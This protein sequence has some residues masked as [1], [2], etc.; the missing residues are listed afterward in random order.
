MPGSSSQVSHVLDAPRPPFLDL[1]DE[2]PRTALAG[3]YE[4]AWRLLTTRPPSVFRQLPEEEREDLISLI[5]ERCSERAF[6]RLRTYEDRG[7]P[8]ACWL[9]TEA[10]FRA[11]DRLRKLRRHRLE[12][13]DPQLP[14]PTAPPPDPGLARRLQECMAKLSEK[15]QLLLQCAA[16]GLRPREVTRLMG[17]PEDM[18]A[19]ASDDTRY[20]MRKLKQCLLDAGLT[21]DEVLA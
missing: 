15:C 18:N 3:F 6:A 1:L 8:F 7:K 14:A 2:D 11:M 16:D 19:K 4:F 13:L 5:V 10:H 9:V 12:E 21:V 20:C 17:W